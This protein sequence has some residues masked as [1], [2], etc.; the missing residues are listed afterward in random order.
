MFLWVVYFLAITLAHEIQLNKPS[1]LSRNTNQAITSEECDDVLLRR[2]RSVIPNTNDTETTTLSPEQQKI[3]K[4]R[5]SYYFSYHSRFQKYYEWLYYLNLDFTRRLQRI[6]AGNLLTTKFDYPALQ[7]E[8]TPFPI[9]FHERRQYHY[10]SQL[11]ALFNI[12]R[13]PHLQK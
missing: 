13:S 7:F 2:R 8:P 1:H 9:P 10:V 5:K 4:I 3:E 6:E 11:E 12:T